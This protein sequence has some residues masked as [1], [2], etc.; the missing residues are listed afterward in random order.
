MY[1]DNITEATVPPIGY[2]DN[3]NPIVILLIPLFSANPG[4]KLIGNRNEE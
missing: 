2:N 4:K 3:I 1:F